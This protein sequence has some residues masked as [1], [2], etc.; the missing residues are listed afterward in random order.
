MHT[1]LLHILIQSLLI[2]L[3]FRLSPA[4]ASPAPISLGNFPS[5]HIKR[6]SSQPRAPPPPKPNTS[7]PDEDPYTRLTE[8]YNLK[9]KHYPQWI[10]EKSKLLWESHK[11]RKAREAAIRDYTSPY[12]T[13]FADKKDGWWSAFDFGRIWRHFLW[14]VL[15]ELWRK[16]ELPR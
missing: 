8:G 6:H 9:F 10:K 14:E 13:K 7:P 16:S 11:D 2:L 12:L 3:F 1:R 15:P 5:S 4:Y